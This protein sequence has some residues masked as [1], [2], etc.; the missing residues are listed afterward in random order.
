MQYKFIVK[1]RGEG[2][3]KQ[4]VDFLVDSEA[5]G[6]GCVYVGSYFSYLAVKDMYENT[7]HQRCPL[8]FASSEDAVRLTTPMENVDFFTDE[9][10]NEMGHVLFSSLLTTWADKLKE[11]CW[12]ITIDRSFVV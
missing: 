12:Y 3:T 5:N 4:L 1:G 11:S 6:R 9:L 7:M 8:V 10:T 2:K